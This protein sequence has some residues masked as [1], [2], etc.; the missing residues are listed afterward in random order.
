MLVLISRW[1]CVCYTVT[2]SPRISLWPLGGVVFVVEGGGVSSCEAVG[3]PSPAVYVVARAESHC[4]G[5]N[6]G[7]EFPL[8]GEVYYRAC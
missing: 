5:R 4:V 2:L 7:T 8:P 3:D 1:G 6:G